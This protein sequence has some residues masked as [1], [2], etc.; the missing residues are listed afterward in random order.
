MK[1]D[2]RAV[3]L[4]AALFGTS[5]G[6][7]SASDPVVQGASDE[8]LANAGDGSDPLRAEVVN[9]LRKANRKDLLPTK[10]AVLYMVPP[11]TQVTLDANYASYDEAVFAGLRK[12]LLTRGFVISK[13]KAPQFI[14]CD[15]GGTGDYLELVKNPT[16]ISSAMESTNRDAG[17]PPTYTAADI[18]GAKAIEAKAMYRLTLTKERVDVY[19][20]KVGPKW[21]ILAVD[22]AFH[23]CDVLKVRPPGSGPG[24][25]GP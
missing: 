4:V 19:L 22:G 13:G 5:L 7:A 18:E 25:S 21:K 14:P 23:S 12:S 15:P 6:C 8:D 24:T 3:C 1:T 2:L 20:G 10:V 11:S 9:A 17:E 16:F